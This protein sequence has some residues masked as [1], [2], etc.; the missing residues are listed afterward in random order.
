MTDTTLINYSLIVAELSKGLKPVVPLPGYDTLDMV[1]A[2]KDLRTI[3]FSSPSQSGASSWAKEFYL[4]HVGEAILILRNEA[5]IT[6]MFPNGL[7]K[8]EKNV[9]TPYQAHDRLT[10]Y[11]VKEDLSSL[12][13]VITDSLVNQKLSDTLYAWLVR[14][15]CLDVTIIAVDSTRF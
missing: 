7:E 8:G 10:R 2:I 15:E 1:H 11:H 4:K 6:D 3:G 9:L 5:L 12:K 14:N 13:Y